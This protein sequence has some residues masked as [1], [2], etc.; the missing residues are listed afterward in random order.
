MNFHKTAQ[1][2]EENYPFLGPLRELYCFLACH[3]KRVSI[4]E[5]KKLLALLTLNSEEWRF[6]KQHVKKWNRF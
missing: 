3:L 1:F 5:K 6:H 4:F 2:K